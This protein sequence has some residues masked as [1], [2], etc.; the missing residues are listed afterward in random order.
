MAVL[1]IA[2]RGDPIGC[3]ENTLPAF[4]AS[5]RAGADM[6]E[7]DV[8]R[9][10]DG[11]VVVVHD[12]TLQRIWGL[13]RRVGETTLAAVRALGEGERRIPEFADVLA[14]VDLPVMVDFKRTDV[15]EPALEVVRAAGALERCLFS[16]GNVEGHRLLRSLAPEARIALTWEDRRLPA[17]ALLDELEVE[18]LNP[19]FSV[20]ESRM[21]DAMR[22]RGTGVSTWTIDESRE[23]ARA[24]GLGVDAIVTNRMDRLRAALA[25]GVRC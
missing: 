2:H 24:L 22:E 8:Q 21:I 11:A 10:S 15:V 18:Y 14:A 25:E 13:S 12:V 20:V 23:L 1:A 5:V 6:I 3:V 9:T 19:R 17:D 7:L 4:E 16:G